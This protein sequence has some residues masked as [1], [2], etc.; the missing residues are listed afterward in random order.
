MKTPSPSSEFQPSKNSK[1]SKSSSHQ[2]LSE[3]KSKFLS[4]SGSS[5]KPESLKNTFDDPAIIEM[6]SNA[7][8]FKNES[9]TDPASSLPISSCI[10]AYASDV[11]QDPSQSQDQNE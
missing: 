3:K 5:E 7:S 4:S 9:S 11:E 10:S 1:R 8:S 2:S 6:M